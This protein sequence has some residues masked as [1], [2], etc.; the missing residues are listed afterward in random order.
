[1][2]ADP[3]IEDLTRLRALYRRR[4]PRDGRAGLQPDGKIGMP[5]RFNLAASVLDAQR[6]MEMDDPTLRRWREGMGLDDRVTQWSDPCPAR[7]GG[8][9]THART[10]RDPQGR[11]A[12]CHQVIGSR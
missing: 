7:V 3:R 2:S 10:F 6:V 11:C 4:G 5:W 1:M 8:D 9:L 12:H